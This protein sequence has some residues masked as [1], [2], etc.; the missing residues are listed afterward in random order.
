MET[1]EVI[2]KIAFEKLSE[3]RKLFVQAGYAYEKRNSEAK[4][5]KENYV[6]VLLAISHLAEAYDEV[7]AIYENDIQ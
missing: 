3:T 6:N 4:A 2:M 5:D 1:P 7:S